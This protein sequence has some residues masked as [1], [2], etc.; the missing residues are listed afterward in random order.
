[1]QGDALI[2]G[3]ALSLEAGE[4]FD[5]SRI[6]LALPGRFVTAVGDAE[7]FSP[8]R[9]GGPIA[10]RTDSA[11]ERFVREQLAG[12][13]IVGFATELDALEALEAGEVGAFF[14]DAMRA[15]LWLDENPECCG[16]AGRAYGRPDSF[17]AGLASA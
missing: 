17:G 4:S 5:F 3:L 1:N 10:V 16:F 11:H 8:E 15:A 9:P 2:A 6:Y 13:E 14:G 12:A 7:R